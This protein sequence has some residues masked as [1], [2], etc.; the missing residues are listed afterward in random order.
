MSPPRLASRAGQVTEG[1]PGQRRRRSVLSAVRILRT[2]ELRPDPICFPEGPRGHRDGRGLAEPDDTDT[3]VG[4][5]CRAPGAA[6]GTPRPSCGRGFGYKY[7]LH[8]FVLVHRT[9]VDVCA[10][11]L[12]P[13]ALCS[14][15]SVPGG[16]HTF[17]VVFICWLCTVSGVLGTQDLAR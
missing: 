7:E 14:C 12:C 5:F 16:D 11:T 13:A 2:S 10:S 17:T 6:R 3:P 8:E 9:A 15:S 4:S 1:F